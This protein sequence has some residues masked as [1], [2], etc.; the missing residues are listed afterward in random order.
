MWI[1]LLTLP[2][3]S[4]IAQSGEISKMKEDSIVNFKEESNLLLKD[5]FLYHCLNYGLKNNGDHILDKD[6]SI[7][8]Y[9][10]WLKIIVFENDFPDLKEYALKTGGDVKFSLKS[11]KYHVKT[12]LLGHCL[13]AY[14]GETLDS[15]VIKI[16]DR[17]FKKAYKQS[18]E[19]DR[20]KK[21]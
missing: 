17:L 11:S 19:N 21:K 3:S 8:F 12:S 4:L 1:V 7:K 10:S 18:Y 20:K 2:M 5:Y 15:A 16:T 6:Q 14:R 9:Q 13:N